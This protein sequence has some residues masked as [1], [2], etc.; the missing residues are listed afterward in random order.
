IAHRRD[1]HLIEQERGGLDELLMSVVEGVERARIEHGRHVSVSCGSASLRRQMVTTVV[2]YVRVLITAQPA[3][4]SIGRSLSST[5]TSAPSTTPIEPRALKV[6]SRTRSLVGRVA[7]PLGAIS[8]SPPAV[9]ATT[10]IDAE[11]NV[12]RMP[13]P[14]SSVRVVRIDQPHARNAV[15]SATA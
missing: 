13:N 5:A 6:A 9:P 3:P 12:G 1:D 10:R 7:W 8:F 15:N 2:P 4:G 11:P 14:K